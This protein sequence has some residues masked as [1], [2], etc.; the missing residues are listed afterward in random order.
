MIGRDEKKVL[1][2]KKLL[3]S[4]SKGDREA[5]H[6]IFTQHFDKV[7]YFINAI[8]KSDADAEDLA[9]DIFVKIWNMKELMDHVNSLNAYMYKMARNSAISYTRRK[10][11]N[12]VSLDTIE[13]SHVNASPEEE[14]YAK[15][16][17]LLI[18]LVLSNM[19]DQRRRI[20]EM[21][22]EAGFSNEDIAI[23]LNI[24]KHTVENNISLALKNIKHALV[25]LSFFLPIIK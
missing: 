10:S 24:S 17:E 1:Y 5:F 20:Y 18:K 19:S 12:S 4:L 22:R 2:E 16:K 6:I 14:Y 9:Q 21:S 25:S 7:K 11:H 8:I 3:L 23:Q 13:Y 15:E